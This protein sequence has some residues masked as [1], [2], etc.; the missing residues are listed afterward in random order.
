MSNST[1][2]EKDL[3]MTVQ[4]SS[5]MPGCMMSPS[6]LPIH[7]EFQYSRIKYCS[8]PRKRVRRW[9]NILRRFMRESKTLCRSKPMSF[10]YDPVS[11]SQN[12]DEGCH[13][14]E[15]RPGLQEVRRKRQMLCN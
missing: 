6:C 12:F 11:Y 14:D 10:Q 13:L 1:P 3:T 2:M 9:R 4:R 15:P 5:Y 8:N 7:N